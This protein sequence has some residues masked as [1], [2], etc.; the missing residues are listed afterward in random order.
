VAQGWNGDGYG[1]MAIPRIGQE[2]IVSYLNGDIDRPIITGCTYNGRNAPPL[3]LPKD[4]TRTT[5]RTKT[6]KGT[7]FNELRFE[8]AGGRE[9]VYLHAQ[10]D[11]NIHVQHDSHWHTQ[12]N[13]KHRIDNQRFTE[14]AG[15]DHL[16]MKGTQKSLIEGD[17]SLQ[18]KGAKHSKIDDE[19]IVESGMETSFK[20][21]GKIILEAG[22]EITLK[23]G[24]SFIRLTPSAIFTSGNLDIGSSGPGTGQSPIIQLPDGVIPFEQPPYA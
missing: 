10:R 13:F 9:E 14:I 22:T 8:D 15:D 5:F 1:F 7:G 20:S 16:I 21:G 18:I 3:D 12:H 17:V 2:V 11:L 4:K 19:L 6:H 23:V 24:S